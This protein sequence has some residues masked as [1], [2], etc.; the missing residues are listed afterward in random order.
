MDQSRYARQVAC[1]E[2]GRA[3]Q[4]RLAGARVAVVGCGA[5]GSIAASLLVRAGTGA[6]RLIDRDFVELNNLQRQMLYEE[7][8]VV[9]GVPKAVA[10]AERL[11]RA[12]SEVKV[13]PV[14]ADFHSTNAV[15]LL[16]DCDVLVDA[17]DSFETR[18]LINDLAL[19]TGT[20]WVYGALIGTYGVVMAILPGETA[21]LRCL[22]PEPPAPGTVE[23]CDTAGVIG[24]IVTAVASFQV[25]EVMKLL[26]G[27][28]EALCD[29]ALQIDVWDGE[30][31]RVKVARQPDCPA[32]VRGQLTYLGAAHTSRTTSVCGRDAVQVSVP[33]GAGLDLPALAARLRA[34]GEVVENAFMLKMRVD[35]YELNIFPDA[36]AIIKG[37]TDEVVARTLY[38]R[39]VG[40]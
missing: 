26:C 28:R 40:T 10:A 9:S 4:A 31:R 1:L 11:R 2:I 17:V 36:R 27:A 34:A 19:S 25:T 35:G 33:A 32:C 16:S 12:N 7:D 8:D 18:Y 37:T 38:A 3:G 6:V 23:T 29:G 20:P 14:V 15:A 39:Y 21:C 22:V 5:L 30:A 24:P 13:E